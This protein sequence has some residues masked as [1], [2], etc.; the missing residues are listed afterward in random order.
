MKMMVNEDLAPQWQRDIAALSA[1][2]DA[3]LMINHRE[4]HGAAL[5]VMAHLQKREES[6]PFLKY[7]PTV[8]NGMAL[9][10]NR[11]T[12]KHRDEQTWPT[13]YDVLATVGDYDIG[14]FAISALG[15]R[16]QYPSGTMIALCGGVL[17]HA[18]EIVSG[19]RVCWAYFMRRDLYEY[20]DVKL[21][22]WSEIKNI[23]HT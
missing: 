15:I 23:L 19:E 10:S 9:I 11:Q 3:I 12:P 20:A 1:V 2:A 13:W 14:D 4:L 8:F 5:E 7:W 6:Q 22:H 18:A 21:A 16:F 17:E